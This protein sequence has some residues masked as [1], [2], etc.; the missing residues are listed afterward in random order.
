MPE[1]ESKKGGNGNKLAVLARD[2]NI[3]LDS[4]STY[5]DAVYDVKSLECIVK[6]LIPLIEVIDQSNSFYERVMREKMLAS[7]NPC[8]SFLSKEMI[9]RLVSHG[10]KYTQLEDICKEEKENALSVITSIFTKKNKAGKCV[11]TNHS[12][13]IGNVVKY[14]IDLPKN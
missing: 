4:A 14:F 9:D 6:A 11:I 5:H 7:Y 10:I 8:R 12:K 2:F 3:H 13:I 1:R